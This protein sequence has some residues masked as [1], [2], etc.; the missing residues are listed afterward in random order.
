M[1]AKLAHTN[2]KEIIRFLKF[3]AVGT[4]GAV[5]DFGLL[6]LLV[7]LAHFPEDIAKA[8]S[9]TAAVIS[10]F[11]WNR[12]WVYPETRGDP[13]R[14]QFVQFSVVNVAGLIIN[15]AIFKVSFWLLG[16]TGLLGSPTGAVALAIGMSHFVLALNSANALATGVVLFW[17][18]FINRLW[19]FRHVR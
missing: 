5:I 10:N 6:N 14:K 1:I 7:Q 15:M 11:I 12:L 4:L 9:F 16:E 2:Q 18:F 13:L 3:A 17:N 8:C 19:T